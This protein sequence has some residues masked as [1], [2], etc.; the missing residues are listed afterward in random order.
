M[1]MI[2]TSDELNVLALLKFLELFQIIVTGTLTVI[3]QAQ[4]RAVVDRL[5]RSNSTSE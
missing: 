1:H 2:I 3:K 5:Y 4:L